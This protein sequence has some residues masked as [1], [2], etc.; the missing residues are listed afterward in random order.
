[1][2]IYI[3]KWIQRRA[4]N[5]GQS[6]Y[7]R[8][9]FTLDEIPAKAELFAAAAGLYEVFINGVKI[10]D[11]VLTPAPGQY[12]FRVEYTVYQVRQFLKKGKNIIVFQLGN[13]FYNC[14]EYDYSNLNHAAFKDFPKFM[15]YLQFD[16][17][18]KVVTDD[19]W[20]TAPSGITYNCLRHGEFFDANM[21]PDNI[22]DPE[23]EDASWVNATYCNPPGGRI[24]PEQG[25][26]CRVIERIAPVNKK[27]FPFG[28]LVY[29]F[30]V[31]IAGWCEVT[32][33]APP[34]TTI[35]LEYGEQLTDIGDVSRE[36]IRNLDPSPVY[37][38][39]RFTVGKSG[40]LENAHTHFTWYGFRYVRMRA[41]NPNIKI[42][43]I[44]ACTV[45]NDFDHIGKYNSS[46]S[47]LN[48]L[49]ELT[50]RSFES[51]FVGIPTDCPHREKNGWTGD[52][53]LAC[54]TGLF[55]YDA[56]TDYGHY[57]DCVVGT[58]RPNGQLA[59][60]APSGI[61][62][63][64]FG[65]G[66]AWDIVLFAVPYQIYRFTG[67]KTYIERYYPNMELYLDYCLQHERED[68]LLYNGLGDWCPVEH[69]R[70]TETVI[71]STGCYYDMA[72]KMA[73][74]AEVL[75]KNDDAAKYQTLAAKIRTAFRKK[76]VK[77]NGVI[78]DDTWAAL[79]C[80]VYF[81]FLE[82]D[83]NKAVCDR[84]VQKIRDNEHKVDFGILGAKYVPHALANN[85]Y[86]SDALKLFTQTEYPGWGYW[87]KM[88]ATTLWETWSGLWSRNHIMFGDVA[89]WCFEHLGGIK[90][91]AGK[92]T[93]A[94]V[95]PDGLDFFECEH[96]IPDKGTIKVRWEKSSDKKV[97]YSIKTDGDFTC[98]VILPDGR[99]DTLAA[100]SE[101]SY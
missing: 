77:D 38:E 101:K 91:N 2:N 5:S 23:A 42:E 44:E 34:G 27:V 50:K 35:Y 93:F 59:C 43:K 61:W 84:L 29:D 11:R 85:G 37:Q 45:Y 16:G 96:T 40:R 31:N 86:V 60:I 30:G 81:D 47:V 56:K 58:Q 100:F 13:G 97:H 94:P 62:G 99:T 9:T 22:H 72:K 52:V 64:N 19:S 76:F 20:Q 28:R 39:Q 53:Q 10:D 4:E 89:N 55:L 26:P 41:E 12:D 1:M 74:F 25:H 88:G 83:E 24:V 69:F 51:N 8:K 3:A 48:K 32:F 75:G 21:E 49:L 63:Y 15:A 87:V 66:P 80:A 68:G 33:T 95:I 54:E 14:F 6:Y 65:C 71:T 70:M 18:I 73:Y 90:M 7:F 82:A 98:N 79:G 17:D 67:D 46:D 92:I 78:G 57:L 36:F